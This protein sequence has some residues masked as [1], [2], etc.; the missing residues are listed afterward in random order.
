MIPVQRWSILLVLLM[1][2]LQWLQAEEVMVMQI[3][4][5]ITPVTA[6]FL[7]QVLLETNER[8]S[9]CLILQLDTPGGLMTSMRQMNKA[10]LASERPV[11]VYVSP[12]GAQAAS[13]G[14]FIAM[15]S[16]LVAMA[17]ETNIGAA[18]PVTM[19]AGGDSS[20]VMLAKVTNDAVATIRSLATERGR[21][22]DWAEQAVR[23]SVSIS[24][25]EALDLGVIELIAPDLDN[26]LSQ[27]DGQ[28]LRTT[29]GSCTLSVAQAAIRNVEMDWRLRVLSTISDPN[30]AYILLLIGLYG[31]MFELYNPGSIL[32]GV[33]GGISLLLAFFAMQT[34]PVS[35]A[36]I[37]LILFA[38]ILFLAE[39]KVTSYGMLSVGGVIAMFF[40]SVM[41]FDSPL[42]FMRV[43]WDVVLPAVIFTALFFLF[44]LGAALRAQKRKATTGS[45]GM[46]GLEG[47]CVGR[48]D[49]EG[50][51]EVHGE[52]W[53]ARLATGSETAE[54]GDPVRVTGYRNLLLLVEPVIRDKDLN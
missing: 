23:E 14:V 26:L 3:Q 41:L 44:A 7:D 45:E 12:A 46:I 17:P 22:A 50:Q 30:I 39:I 47:K 48:L 2:P 54:A 27:L 33:M 53:R 8:N 15:A 28:V 6:D 13:A 25:R 31:I 16:H 36:G 4:S 24:A 18:H 40:G 20:E 34:L 37:G 35:A 21:N 11:I 1:L 5:A 52:I 43:S 19:G 38:I 29:D 42:E 51:I 49:P 10:I 9:Q 32:P